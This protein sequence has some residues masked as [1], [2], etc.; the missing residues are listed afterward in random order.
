MTTEPM[1]KNE[2]PTPTFA[3]LIMAIIIALMLAAAIITPWGVPIGSTL[4]LVPFYL[5]AWPDKAQH[6]RNLR[7]QGKRNRERAAA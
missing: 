6:D 5:W 2:L 4:M 7:E 3:P 1:Y